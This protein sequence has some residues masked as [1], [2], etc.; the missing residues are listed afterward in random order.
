LIQR[1][2]VKYNPDSMNLSY[3][4][5][6]ISDIFKTNINQKNINFNNE[7]DE[8]TY[9]IAD[10]NMLQTILRNLISNAIKYTRSVG[11][12]NI[13]ANE[14]SPEFVEITVS[15][16]GVGMDPATCGNLFK[17]SSAGSKPGTSNEKGTGLGLILCKDLVERLGGTIRVES[18][19]GKGSS[20]SFTVPKYIAETAMFAD[21]IV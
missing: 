16:D 15:D 6:N 8:F 14:T 5:N 10:A 17:I 21:S 19:P 18:Q 12:I 3:I 9:V 7:I 2:A 20:F 13:L 1:G 11:N 4:V